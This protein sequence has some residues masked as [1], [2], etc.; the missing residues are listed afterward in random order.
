MKFIL[1]SIL[2]LWSW[3]LDN[4]LNHIDK[5]HV[6]SHCKGSMNMWVCTRPSSCPSSFT[7]CWT[8]D[9][10][11]PLRPNS[12]NYQY[13]TRLRQNQQCH[14]GSCLCVFSL[15]YLYLTNNHVWYIHVRIFV[16]PG[17]WF[18]PHWWECCK[19]PLQGAPP[20]CGFVHVRVFV[21]VPSQVAEQWLHCPHSDKTP[22]TINIIQCVSKN[23][24]YHSLGM[25]TISNFYS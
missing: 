21:L 15:M 8:L 6:K 4:V 17:Q 16:I 7:S 20:N 14:S 11:A 2:S 24:Q 5:S 25:L 23:Q 22:S 10:L 3:G 13:Y 12:I 19:F 9:P 1:K 18:A